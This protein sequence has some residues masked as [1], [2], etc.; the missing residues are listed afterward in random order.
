VLLLLL[1][2]VR[3]LEAHLKATQG[4][5]S[6]LQDQAELSRKRLVNAG[7]LLSALGSE[8]VRWQDTT[9]QLGERMLLLVGDCLLSAACISYLGAFTGAHTLRCTLAAPPLQTRICPAPTGGGPLTVCSA[10][11]T[12]PLVDVPHYQLWSQTRRRCPHVVCCTLILH[13]QSACA[14]TRQQLP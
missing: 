13:Q 6:S 4:E 7:K 5:L 11:C 12:E 14:I 3:G 1:L 8:A 9:A 2:Q 10:A